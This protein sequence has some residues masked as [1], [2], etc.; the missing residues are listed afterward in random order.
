MRQP[1]YEVCKSVSVREWAL[2][3]IV[4]SIIV[5]YLKKYKVYKYEKS[6]PKCMDLD[7]CDRWIHG[8]GSIGSVVFTTLIASL[9]GR[10]IT[11]KG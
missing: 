5:E 7:L 6:L 10:R 8:I 3:S 11:G 9:V 2:T 4:N 1:S